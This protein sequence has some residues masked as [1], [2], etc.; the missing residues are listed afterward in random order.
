MDDVLD[1][2]A[3]ACDLLVD[4]VYGGTSMDRQIGALR[5]GVDVV[6]GCWAR[7][8]YP[9]NSPATQC[10]HAQP[11]TAVV[12]STVPTIQALVD[13]TIA[14]TGDSIASLRV[15]GYSRGAGVAVKGDP[16]RHL[17][18][19]QRSQAVEFAS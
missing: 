2:L 16:H 6:V 8:D 4:A 19:H 14:A 5:N 18:L 15:L 11:R 7:W 10:G 13:A 3:R 12:E 9:S 1:P 17:F